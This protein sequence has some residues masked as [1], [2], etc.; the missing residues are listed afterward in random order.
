M[1]PT[2]D[3]FALEPRETEQEARSAAARWAAARRSAFVIVPWKVVGAETV[4]SLG[5]AAATG[6]AGMDIANAVT[7][8]A[9]MLNI[10]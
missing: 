8:I 7:S 6:I 3:G 5:L 4:Q 10:F 1:A 9:A 2:T